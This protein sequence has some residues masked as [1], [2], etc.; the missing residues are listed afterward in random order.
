MSPQTSPRAG[1][2]RHALTEVG[3]VLGFYVIYT[4]VRNMFGSAGVGSDVALANA[5]ELIEFERSLNLYVELDVQRLFI[6]WDGFIWSSNIFYG[7]FHFVVTP[8]VLV[9]LFVHHQ[10]DYARLRTTLLATTGLALIG[11][12]IFPVM[13][14]RLLGSCGPYGGCVPSGF[15]DTIAEVGGVWS[16]ES[17]SVQSVSNQFAAVPS[18]HMAWALWCSAALAAR[19]RSRSL[20]PLISLYPLATLFAIVVTANHYWIDAVLGALTL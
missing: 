11:F 8:A 18:L 17:K 10:A 13:P 20:L 19:V 1:G 16:F 15:V 2:K 4:F 5:R 3:L 7:T 6:D 14:P 12:T 9:W